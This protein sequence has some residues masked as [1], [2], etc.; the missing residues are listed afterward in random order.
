M[1]DYNRINPRLCATATASVRLMASRVVG[2]AFTC[3]LAV[4]S[5]MDRLLKMSSSAR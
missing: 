5:L 1:Q 4:L 3:V 2:M